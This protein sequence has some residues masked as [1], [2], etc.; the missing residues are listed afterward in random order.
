MDLFVSEQYL[1]SVLPLNDSIDYKLLKLH[2]E[3]SQLKF[4]MP[5]L[6]TAYYDNLLTRYISATLTTIESDELV[7]TIK[8]IIAYK[9]FSRAVITVNVNIANNGI[10]TRTGAYFDGSDKLKEIAQLQREYL[11][12]ANFWIDYALTILR[13]YPSSFPLWKDSSTNI[14]NPEPSTQKGS[15]NVILDYETRKY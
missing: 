12:D 15:W 11:A 9:A 10:T 3:E 14:I 2:C 6:G 5:L 13:K 4:I 8:R 7:P 1:K